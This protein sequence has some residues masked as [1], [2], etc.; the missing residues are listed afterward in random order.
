MQE[1]SERLWKAALDAMKCK[2]FGLDAA[3]HESSPI[4]AARIFTKEDDALTKDWIADTVFL[5]APFSLQGPFT[6]KLI[7]EYKL[8]H[9]GEAVCLSKN[10]SRTA[11]WSKL[12]EE[13][14]A[15]CIVTGYD[16]FHKPEERGDDNKSSSFFSIVMWYFGPNV[17]Q[18][19]YAFNSVGIV[20]QELNPEMFGG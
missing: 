2:E 9:F 20:V 10:D 11:W 4:P 15:F 18:F 1:T 6:D 3:S 17:D 14:T 13:C 8:E 5:N 16:K 7:E 12:A 19:F